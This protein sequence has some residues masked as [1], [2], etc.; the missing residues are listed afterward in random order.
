MF[1]LE[2]HTYVKHL[3]RGCPQGSKLGPTLWKVAMTAIGD[4]ALEDTA[5]IIVYADNITV[6][7]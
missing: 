5:K 3:Q 1:D 6:L 7:G 2:G 4:I